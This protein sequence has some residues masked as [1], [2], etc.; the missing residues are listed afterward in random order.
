[1]ET[2]SCFR[3]KEVINVCDGMRLGYVC[4]L[5]LDLRS[6]KICKIIVPEGNRFFGVLCR[7]REFRIP[8]DCIRRIGDDVIL[9][10][11]ILDEMMFVPE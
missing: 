10:D 6:G 4:D 1:M 2:F 8:W 9:V 11:I 7:E 3:K 5:E